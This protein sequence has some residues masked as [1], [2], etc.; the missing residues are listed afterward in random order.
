[1]PEGRN[2][3]RE[4]SYI[5]SLVDWRLPPARLR[6]RPTC[7]DLIERGVDVL[8]VRERVGIVAIILTGRKCFEHIFEQ[9]LFNE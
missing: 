1:M 3:L 5:P 4:A 9:L 8:G 2:I 6:R 7:F